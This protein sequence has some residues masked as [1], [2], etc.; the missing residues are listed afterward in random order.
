MTNDTHLLRQVHPKWYVKGELTPDAFGP[1][2][3]QNYELSVYDGDQISAENSY[4]HYRSNG[5]STVGVVAVTA[6]EATRQALAVRAAPQP[7]W[8]HHAVIDYKAAP[9][10]AAR[11]AAAR[12]LTVAARRRDWVHNTHGLETMR[13]D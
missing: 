4:S 12:K 3:E 13:P 7:K 2:R 5:R 11:R 1:S 9:D 6:A 10:K 8:P